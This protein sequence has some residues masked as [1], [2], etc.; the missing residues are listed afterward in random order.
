[1]NAGS[2]PPLT[3]IISKKSLNFGSDFFCLSLSERTVNALPLPGSTT[4]AAG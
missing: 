4:G 2:N 1:M 3:A